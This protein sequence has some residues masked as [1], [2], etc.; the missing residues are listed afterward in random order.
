[1][2]YLVKNQESYGSKFVSFAPASI[3]ARAL[4]VT[5][6]QWFYIGNL[7]VK[8]R[9]ETKG[10]SIFCIRTEKVTIVWGGNQ[11]FEGLYAKKVL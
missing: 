11:G 8:S 2:V 5:M 10:V 7:V 1:M 9:L 3:P 4:M 6:P